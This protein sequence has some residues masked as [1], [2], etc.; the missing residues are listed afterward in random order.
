MAIAAARRLI[1]PHHNTRDGG[2]PISRRYIT[3]SQAPPIFSVTLAVG[4]DNYN[5][6]VEESG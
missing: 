6:M 4:S 3:H 5:E 1:I 2:V